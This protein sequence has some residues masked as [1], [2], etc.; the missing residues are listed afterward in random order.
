[1]TGP[2]APIV[3]LTV[4]VPVP[5]IGADALTVAIARPSSSRVVVMAA[6]F[7]SGTTAA[8]TVA[9]TVTP[10]SLLSTFSGRAKTSST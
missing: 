5:V 4:L 6:A 8:F 10:R 1:V 9:W 3:R 7:P 2:I